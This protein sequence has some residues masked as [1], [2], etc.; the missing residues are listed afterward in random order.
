MQ[1]LEPRELLATGGVTYQ[2]GPLINNVAVETVFLGQEWTTDPSLQQNAAQLDQ[3]FG[4][5]TNSTFM[6]LLA[7]Y[8]TP[9]GGPIGHGSFVGQVD[10]AQDPWRR[11]TISDTA[12]Q[13]E[14]NSEI[15]NGAI[16]SPDSNRLLFVFT[17][18]D[19]VVSQGGSRS[20]GY[21]TGFAG[22]HNSF[23][24][25]AG[26]LVRYAVI[27]DPIGNDQVEGLT[28]FQQQSAAASHEL[29]E[30]VTDPDG[31]SWWDN[32][33]D[34]TS[35][36]EI[37]DFADLNTDT[38]YLNG[39]VIEEIWSN[40]NGGLVAPLGATLT[41]TP[42]TTPPITNPTPP[43]GGNGNPPAA[44]GL[45]TNIGA[46]AESLAHGV[47]YDT[48]FITTAYQAYL[49]RPVDVAGLN[50][51]ITQMQLGTTDEQLEASLLAST[52]YVANHGGTNVSWV[53][54][55]YEDLL[56]RP[57]DGPGLSYWLDQL[58]AGTNRYQIA[59]EIASS[60]E[61]EA[62]VVTNDYQTFLG[63]L[64][65]PA[66][67]DYW[68]NAFEH[69]A[70]NEDVIAGFIASPEYYNSPSKGQGD[71][72]VWLD[73]VYHD[74]YQSTPTSSDLAYWLGQLDS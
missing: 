15:L 11:S 56:D 13:S 22:Y 72:T 62:I 4:S 52:E 50:Y 71:N 46:V 48:S 63:R 16:A 73:S 36:E 38:L 65:S 67:I 41:A 49:G 7:Q 60:A 3:F 23:I 68:V 32:T 8:G 28:A 1:A 37:G 66:E 20:N 55:M 70:H 51:W 12:I 47:D 40:A 29:A 18:P 2:G 44:P 25:S 34:S 27:P 59:L 61:R 31:T 9:Q 26:Q 14:L 21:P 74:L 42:I 69:G 64:A 24:D 58:Q 17:P 19:I 5:I 33:N 53:L 10:I 35:G 45:P 30:A 6:D 57:A 43:S 39:Y 54:G